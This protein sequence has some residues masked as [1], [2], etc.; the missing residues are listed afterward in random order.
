MALRQIADGLW[1]VEDETPLPGGVWLP[2]RATIVQLAG[3]EL[4]VHSP[5]PFR[6]YLAQSVERLGR[7]AHLVAP[8]LLHHLS[9]AHWAQ[10]FPTAQ[11]W[12][13]EELSR[14]RPDLH[15]SGALDAG[16]APPW[17]GELEP[18]AL[19]GCP[20]LRETVFFHKPTR[21]LLCSDLLFH[22]RTPR[23]WA[24]SLVLTLAGTRG[25]FA[26]SRAWWRYAADRPA[27]KASLARV[28][29]WPFT[30]V[31]VGHGDVLEA[32]DAPA[33]VR[34]AIRRRFAIP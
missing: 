14:K 29:A 31:V 16:D 20:R 25:R 2:T 3:G 1:T 10:R 24:T 34:A 17:A 7:V 21:T 28:L 9:V 26:M 22:V 33:Q 32:D 30:R 5:T 8:N 23:N 18:L 6:G 19:A 27:L 4:L 13:V 11:V 12:G 15:L